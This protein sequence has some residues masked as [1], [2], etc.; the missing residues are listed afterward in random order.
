M[1]PKGLARRI[2]QELP[3]VLG[4]GAN[5]ESKWLERSN[6]R[7]VYARRR[8][9]VF[10]NIRQKHVSVDKPAKSKEHNS[11]CKQIAKVEKV[12]HIPIFLGRIKK[13]YLERYPQ[14]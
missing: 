11:S 7:T 8:A 5:V 6:C 14:S 4:K 13:L 12:R 2:V 1:D 3:L 9:L 10:L